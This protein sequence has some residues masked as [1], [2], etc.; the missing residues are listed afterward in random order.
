LFQ[1][2]VC[3]PT[4]YYNHAVT[5]S[6][7]FSLRDDIDVVPAV[8]SRANVEDQEHEAAFDAY[9][10]GA[11]FIG[12]CQRISQRTPN[13][14]N[15]N[16]LSIVGNEE[17]RTIARSYF[18]RN[19]LYQMSIYT[20][21]LE[22]F[23]PDRDPLS[24]GMLSE[25]TFRVSG[26]D[27]AVATRDIVQSLAGLRDARGRVVNFV[28]VWIDD[29]TFLVAASYNPV[30]PPLAPHVPDDAL[31]VETWNN[32]PTESVLREHGALLLDALRARF[33]SSETIVVLE[34]Y[35]ASL[36][37][38]NDTCGQAV[39]P[40]SWFGRIWSIFG[41]TENKKRSLDETTASSNKRLRVS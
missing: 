4:F 30:P 11:I 26:I 23:R 10:T 15:R 2:V 8:G 17:H 12:L 39:E 22:E 13:V 38:L 6:D 24:K 19:K 31:P 25:S 32:D 3:D 5:N 16:F 29:T 18:G 40:K 37:E 27:K 14:Q 1:M 7:S 36:S 9:M 20:M 33:H 41:T 21:D 34:D 35:L 28:I